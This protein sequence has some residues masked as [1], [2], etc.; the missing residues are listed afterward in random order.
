MVLLQAGANPDARDAHG[1]TPLHHVLR[2][3]V[4][5]VGLAEANTR[6]NHFKAVH[7]RVKVGCQ[8]HDGCKRTLL[9]PSFTLKN[10]CWMLYNAEQC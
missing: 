2:E 8:H 6:I 4:T 9:Q 3:E 5:A 10:V 1:R 7:A